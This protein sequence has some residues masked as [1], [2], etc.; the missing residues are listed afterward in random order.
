MMEIIETKQE[1]SDYI[2]YE[3][4]DYVFYFHIKFHAI[5]KINQF[6]ANQ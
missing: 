5:E 3:W 4:L 6:Y 2:F 1:M